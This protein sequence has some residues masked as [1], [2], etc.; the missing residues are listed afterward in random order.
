MRVYADPFE[1]THKDDKT[2]VTEA[3]LASERV[4]VAMLTAAFPDIPVV[5]EETVPEAGFASPAA[6]FWQGDPL[7]GP[8]EFVAPNGEVPGLNRPLGNGPPGPRGGQCP[9]MRADYVAPGSPTAN[10]VSRTTAS[11][12]GAPSRRGDCRVA[13]LRSGAKRGMLRHRD[14]AARSAPY[15]HGNRREFGEEEA[16]RRRAGAVHGCQPAAH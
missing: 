7:G 12:P 8:R 2:P 1:G 6:R 11:S 15:G 9:A 14:H 13:S 10:P 3:D 4:I 5:S 16:R